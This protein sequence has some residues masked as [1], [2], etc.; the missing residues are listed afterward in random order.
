MT[1]GF[2]EAPR[3]N[4][5]EWATGSIL[6]LFFINSTNWVDEKMLRYVKSQL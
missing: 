6:M 1:V 3:E 2:C 4:D 5:N